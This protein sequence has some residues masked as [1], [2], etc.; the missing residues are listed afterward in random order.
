VTSR[1][2]SHEETGRFGR[3]SLL[4][5]IGE[6]GMGV[7]HLAE[8]PRG[9]RV[10]LKVLR[11]HVV[12]DDEGRARLAREVTS[13]RRVRSDRVAE[14]HDADPWGTQPYVVTRY[15]QGP[16][17]HE[18]V[19]EAGPLDGDELR[20]LAV[21]LIEAVIAVHEAGVLHRDIKPS[22]VLIEGRHDP[23]LI[24]FGLAKLTED[25]RLT[26]TGWLMGTPGYL[27]PE[28]LYGDDASQAADVHAWAATVVFAATGSTPFG[29]G[30]SMAVMDRARR[31]EHDL[32]GVPEWLRPLL[33]L[34]LAPD[35]GR[36]P[37]AGE[38]LARLT[39]PPGDTG[40]TSAAAVAPPT[41]PLTESRRPPPRPP[42]RPGPPPERRP[43]PPPARSTPGVRTLLTVGLLAVVAA[44]LALAPYVAAAALLVLTWLV[45]AASWSMDAVADRRALKGQ[46]RSDALV[47]VLSAPWHLV[48]SLPGTVVLM[49]A[50]LTTGALPATALLALGA[51]E[52]RALFAGGAV[53]AVVLWW[54]PGSR[55]VRRPTRRALAHA[56]TPDPS[57]WT[58]VAVVGAALLALLLALAS[59]TVWWPDEAAP[60]DP[61]DL[62]P[63]G[64]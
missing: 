44:G 1:S 3:Y 27:A 40:A 57:G 46:R 11:P 32:S 6:G 52:G 38:V 49:L 18:R 23:V 62:L 30:P 45:R 35:P 58:W 29:R 37:T 10:A 48:A 28:V 43:E 33:G 17:L 53:A 60:F 42:D 59:G 12:G 4:A 51:P 55:R 13:L 2:A 19:R 47:Q 7:V 9:E 26:A 15:V 25:S 20:A 22:N 41:R 34:C 39:G 24:D 31:G 63:P 61:R 56:T 16:S 64:F 36:R 5:K 54:G 8:G 14:V 21:G 50:T